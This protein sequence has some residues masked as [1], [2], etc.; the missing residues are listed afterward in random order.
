MSGMSLEDLEKDMQLQSIDNTL[1]MAMIASNSY[2]GFKSLIRKRL[3]KAIRKFE[4][5][6]NKMKYEFGEDALTLH[7]MALLEDETLGFKASHEVNERGHCDITLNFAN[8]TW[9]GEAKK[10]TSGYAYLF[11]GYGQLTERYSTGTVHAQSGG[12]IIYTDNASCKNMI[13][14]WKKHV[15][16]SAPR[17]HLHKDFSVKVCP[18]NSLVLI[19]NHTHTVSGL[20]YEVLHYPINFYH[21][22][23]DPDL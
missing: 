8:F 13:D 4:S 11:K 1:R 7:L 10:H 3:D 18:Q 2:D 14:K 17:I 16:K 6:V 12:L 23:A 5:Q 9:H 20:E 19:S 22:P 15:E 21:K